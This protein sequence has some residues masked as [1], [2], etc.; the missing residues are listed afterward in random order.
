MLAA[1]PNQRKSPS[2]CQSGNMIGEKVVD[3]SMFQWR[4]LAARGGRMMKFGANAINSI[5]IVREYSWR[6][7]TWLM[8]KFWM[9]LFPNYEA[10]VPFV[11][12]ASHW[13]QPST[14]AT[15]GDSSWTTSDIIHTRGASLCRQTNEWKMMLTSSHSCR[16]PC[17]KKMAITC[18][19]WWLYWRLITRLVSPV[20]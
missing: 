2:S 1:V 19:M 13:N 15:S 11:L 7:S 6:L 12:V 18:S 14:V 5:C 10:T 9:L 8:A 3:S 4:L 20:H 17:M 16:V